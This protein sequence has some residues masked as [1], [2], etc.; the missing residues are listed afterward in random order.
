MCGMKFTW[1]RV[2]RILA[3]SALGC[4]VLAKSLHP[5]FVH[6]DRPSFAFLAQ[7]FLFVFGMACMAQGLLLL[8]LADRPHVG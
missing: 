8:R 6:V 3:I 5:D 7:A 4:F 1:L 2:I